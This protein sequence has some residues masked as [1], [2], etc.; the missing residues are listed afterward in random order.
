MQQ[1]HQDPR[2][3]GADGMAER[4]GAAVDVDLVAIEAKL[5]GDGA[6]LGGEGLVGLDKIGRASCRE[7]V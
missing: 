7:R 2:A 3:G 6:G 1:G 5:L 4:D